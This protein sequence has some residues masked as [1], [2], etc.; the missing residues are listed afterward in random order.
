MRMF[1]QTWIRK[2]DKHIHIPCL[3]QPM[4]LSCEHLSAFQ[5][6]GPGFSSLFPTCCYCNSLKDNGSDSTPDF[7]ILHLR[8]QNFTLMLSLGMQCTQEEALG[9]FPAEFWEVADIYHTYPFQS[10][11]YMEA[12]KD[13]GVLQSQYLIN[14]VQQRKPV[15]WAGATITR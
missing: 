9:V 5:S 7:P 11:S 1:N 8:R 10:H 14:R 2:W 3:R 12:V 4:K 15:L 13:L 6:N